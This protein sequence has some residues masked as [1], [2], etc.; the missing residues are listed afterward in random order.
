MPPPLYRKRAMPLVFDENG[1]VFIPYGEL[2]TA[3]SG[4]APRPCDECGKA[5]EKIVPG[6]RCLCKACAEERETTGGQRRDDDRLKFNGTQAWWMTRGYDPVLAT[7]LVQRDVQ[8][9]QVHP[10][11]PKDLHAFLSSEVPNPFGRATASVREAAVAALTLSVSAKRTTGLSGLSQ[12]RS[13]VARGVT[14]GTLTV[15]EPT[16]PHVGGIAASA[17]TAVEPTR[18]HVG[19]GGG[20]S[21]VVGQVLA[22]AEEYSEKKRQALLLAGELGQARVA[23]ACGFPRPEVWERLPVDGP[24][25]GNDIWIRHATAFSHGLL[26][27]VRR[28]IVRLKDWLERTGLGDVCSIDECEGGVLAWF[29]LDEQ[30][31]SRSEG[32][33]VPNSLRNYLVSAHDNFGLKGLKVHEPAFKNVSL[34][35]SR[36]PTP[37]KAATTEVLYRMAHVATSHSSIAVQVYAGGLVLCI[38]AALRVRDAQRATLAFAATDGL[39]EGA[40]IGGKCYTSKHPKRRTPKEMPLWVPKTATALGN[41]AEALE[42]R[43]SAKLQP[44]YIFPRLRVPRGETIAHRGVAFLDGPA[45]S[46]DVIKAMRWILC[47]DNFMTEEEAK[48][49]SGHSA[50]HWAPT[51][52][53]LLAMP[54]ED[55]NEVG[56]WVAALVDAHA[57]RAAMPNAYS[58]RDA[59][60]P[61]VLSVLGEI[62]RRTHGCVLAAGGVAMLPRGNPWAIYSDAPVMELDG[63]AS[64]SGSESD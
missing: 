59:E 62:V 28:A 51:V 4:P 50:R 25:S 1:P 63:E 41:W 26:Q 30:A 22:S 49:F 46:A 37:A 12:P 36:T 3:R 55:R 7:L 53:R 9:G 16:H 2:G 39:P 31:K 27:G 17:S 34:P 5:C 15:R 58:A 19:G 11:A 21:I 35:P 52:A 47:M 61:R 29:V 20:H 56:R 13:T 8:P 23:V 57:R 42:S 18:P 43:V 48:S 6:R 14:G 38:L 54:I 10:R 44:D 40:A 60:A 45:K 24:R 64:T 32:L 33:S